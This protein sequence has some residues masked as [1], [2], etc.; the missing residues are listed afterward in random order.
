MGEAKNSIKKKKKK[1]Q[2]NFSRCLSS[3]LNKEE[4]IREEF[5]VE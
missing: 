4:R 3:F 5:W 2:K 1:G